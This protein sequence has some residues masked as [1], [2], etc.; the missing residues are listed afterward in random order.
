[1]K[2]NYLD[3]I[4]PIHNFIRV[5]N[6]ELEIIDSPAFQRLRRIKQLAGANFTYPG[7]QHTRFEHSLG[8]MHI[9][10]LVGKALKTKGILKQDDIDNI[11]IAALLHDIGHGPFSHMFEETLSNNNSD[12]S[13]EQMGKKIILQTQIGDILSKSG[14]DKKFIAKLA[15]G[16]SKVEFYNEIISGIL[17]ADMMDYLLRDGYY[18]GAEHAKIDH[19]RIIQSLDVYKK[20]LALEKSAVYSFESMMYS[21]YQMFQAVYLHKTVRSVE[22]MLLEAIRLA[23]HEIGLSKLDLD[24]YITLTDDVIMSKLLSI[25]SNTTSPRLCAARTLAKNFQERKLLKCVYERRFTKKSD[26]SKNYISGI[27]IKISQKS[28]VSAYDIFVDSCAAPSMS[29]TPSKKEAQSIIL[30]SHDQGKDHG[31]NKPISE[32]PIISA[33]SG[34]MNILRVYTTNKNRK[35]VEIAANSILGDTIK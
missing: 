9:A 30:I 20:R 29:L 34:F 5:Y 3:I 7:A 13:H 27:K 6:K 8:V 24:E 23:Y 19:I 14:F 2:Q 1:M 4:D 17:S 21:R 18:T 33:M 28:G 11:R 22:V 10:G 25:P 16:Q 32:I 35:K 31:Y 26:I 12:T 15:F